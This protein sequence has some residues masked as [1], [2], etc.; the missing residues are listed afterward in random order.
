MD[1]T[2]MGVFFSKMK[3]SDPCSASP[4]GVPWSHRYVHSEKTGRSLEPVVSTVHFFPLGRQP[5]L[6][7]RLRSVKP[8]LGQI[9]STGLWA[10]RNATVFQLLINE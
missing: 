5:L 2:V 3:S 4:G 1:H 7:A 9:G 8:S 6:Y 10:V